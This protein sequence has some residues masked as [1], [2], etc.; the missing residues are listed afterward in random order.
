MVEKLSWAM[1]ESVLR[2]LPDPEKKKD[3]FQRITGFE[4]RLARHI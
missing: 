4:M 3:E 2:G 1:T